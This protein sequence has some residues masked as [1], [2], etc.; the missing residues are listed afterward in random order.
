VLLIFL[1]QVAVA[2]AVLLVAIW[3]DLM[4]VLAVADLVMLLLQLQPLVRAMMVGTHHLKETTAAQI[5]LEAVAAEQ[6][7]QV[8]APQVALGYILIYQELILHMLVV[9][10]VE[11][12][13]RLE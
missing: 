9:A 7:Q 11:I 4:G 5:L 12:Q 13:V 2:V 1:L 3:A 8:Q 10:L 6:E